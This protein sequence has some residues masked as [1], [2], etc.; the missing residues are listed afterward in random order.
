[1]MYYRPDG[2]RRLVVLMQVTAPVGS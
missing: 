2:T 1:V